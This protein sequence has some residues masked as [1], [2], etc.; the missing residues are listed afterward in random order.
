M[1]MFPNYI[2]CFER[3]ILALL[4]DDTNHEMLGG[5]GKTRGSRRVGVC[6]QKIFRTTP[7]RISE[8]AHF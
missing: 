6:S 3:S 5:Y 2:L 7:Y 8:N 1:G 4:Y